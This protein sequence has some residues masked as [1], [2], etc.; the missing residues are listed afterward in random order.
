MAVSDIAR[1]RAL[2]GSNEFVDFMFYSFNDFLRGVMGIDSLMSPR[3]LTSPPELLVISD[4]LQ[5]PEM[6]MSA[7]ELALAF[8]KGELIP[9]S[10][11]V[12]ALEAFIVISSE[13]T[14]STY[15]E[16]AL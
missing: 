1:R 10:F 12:E 15:T 13:S 9:L 16:A 7:A 3:V 11:T 6:M 4:L 8:T 5:R 14:D 2:S